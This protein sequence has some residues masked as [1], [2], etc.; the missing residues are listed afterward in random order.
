MF[1]AVQAAMFTPTLA[2]RQR[3]LG[4]IG[5]YESRGKG[6]GTPS[7]RYGH[8]WPSKHKPHQGYQ[9]RCRRLLGGFHRG[10]KE[11]ALLLGGFLADTLNR[12][13]QS[14]SLYRALKEKNLG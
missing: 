11:R 3:M 5:P 10:G 6:R 9:E 2:D 12:R 1:L 8:K 14:E 4:E 13:E 7:R